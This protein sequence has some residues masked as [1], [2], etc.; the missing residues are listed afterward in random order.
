MIADAWLSTLSLLGLGFALGVKHALDAD[1]LAAVSTLV[2]ERKSLLGS[3]IVGALWGL[4]HTIA[5]LVAGI[6]VIFLHIE[7]GRRTAQALEFGVAVM[8]IVL[9]VNALWRLARGGHLHVHAHEHSGRVHLHPHVHDGAAQLAPGS[10]HGF[11]LTA[12]PVLVGM[13]H[14]LAGSAAVMLLVLSTIR[15]PVVGFAYITVFG[16]GSIGG[17]LLMSALVSVPFHLTPARFAR[18]HIAVRTLAGIVSLGCGLLMAYDI[19]FAG[20]LFL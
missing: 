18:A 15:S 9:G 12:R 20:G 14:G 6:G 11:G 2:S 8:L 17:M 1:H 13:M 5:L 19:G 3:S 4:G 10:H 16:V 7:I